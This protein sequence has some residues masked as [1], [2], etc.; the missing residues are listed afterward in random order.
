ML[1]IAALC[2]WMVPSPRAQTPVLES[3]NL[4]T[5]KTTSPALIQ[6]E[7]E[8]ETRRGQTPALMLTGL[9][10]RTGLPA[11]MLRL[12]L[13]YDIIDE[14]RLTVAS[15]ASGSIELA[16]PVGIVVSYEPGSRS[17]LELST[18]AI[19]VD[20]HDRTEDATVGPESATLDVALDAGPHTVEVSIE[21]Q[22]G[23]TASGRSDFT[24]DLVPPA[25]T[26]ASPSGGDIVEAAGTLLVEFSVADDADPEP[27]VSADLV[28]TEDLGTPRGELP[29][30]IAVLSGQELLGADLDDGLWELRVSAADKAGRS[31]EDS[32]AFEVRHN[33]PPVAAF[34][35]P[36]MII[37]GA[38]AEFDASTSADADGTI[39]S[40]EW[41]FGNEASGSGVTV[42]HVYDTAGAFTVTLTVTDDD[43]ATDTAA[44][45]VTVKTPAEGATDIIEEITEL[46]LPAGTEESLVSKLENA[47]K[48]LESGNANAGTNQ[49]EAFINSVEAQKGKKL[50]D[51]QAEAFIA[52]AELLI[53]GAGSVDADKGQKAG[54]RNAAVAA[55]SAFRLGEV[56]VFPNPVVGGAA[57]VIHAEVGVADEVTFR[58]Y[59]VAGQRAAVA[60]LE[61]MPS[62][63]NGAYAYEFRWEGRIPSGVYMYTVVAEKSGHA[64][65]RRTGKFAVVR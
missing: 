19:L 28:Q 38:P 52:A 7:L 13:E 41:D 46:G 61:G 56:Y 25:V 9:E 20:G 53:A 1:G 22:A 32:T 4:E 50:T 29:A 18:L 54:S 11:G 23:R 47:A 45:P 2:L 49:L 5:D 30:E 37:Q 3:A 42:S 36:D 33:L 43:D 57:P 65:L 15:P 26:I 58:I 12:V 31:T 8:T 63:V 35:V 24:V 21:D 40:H 51:E 60:T 55:D 10:Y 59:N 27:D 48:S 6:A 62:V 44:S 16:S 17:P 14:P 64:S 39:E 34:S